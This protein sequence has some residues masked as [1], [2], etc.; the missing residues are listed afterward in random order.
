MP[1]ERVAYH[2]ASLRA[3]GLLILLTILVLTPQLIWGQGSTHS[4]IYNLL[5]THQI[6]EGF[7]RGD[8]YPR[9][10]PESFSG[11]GSPTFF[12]YGPFFHLISGA[13]EY[14]GLRTVHAVTGATALV[15]LGSGCGMYAWLRHRGTR[16]LLGAALYMLAPYH[17]F[18]IYARGALAEAAAFIWVPLIAL[19]IDWLPRRRGVVLLGV[20]FAGLILTHLP[21]AV[22]VST[23]L[24][25]PFALWRGWR[26]R[27]VVWP[28][29]VAALL[30]LG[31]SAFYWL[32]ALTLQA[33]ISTQLLWGP[34]Y[35]PAYWFNRQ[36]FKLN[37]LVLYLV[38]PIALAVLAAPARSIWSAVAV[39]AV[40]AILG[41]IPFIWDLPILA[42]TQFP[43]RLLL[44]AEFAAITA[45]MATP[46]KGFVLS[47]GRFLMA[48]PITIAL[49]AM[50]TVPRASLDE[51]AILRHRPDAPEYL[52][53]GLPTPGVGPHQR[54]ADVSAYD[55]LP[56]GE[57]I[58]AT[59]SGSL[60][61]GHA[62]FPIWRVTRDGRRVPSSGPL[63][64]FAAEPGVYRIERKTL[65]QEAWGLGLSSGALLALASL[66]LR[67]A[68]SLE[69]R[70]P[71]RSSP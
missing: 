4:G 6:A 1:G 43:F 45:I 68:M 30:G 71:R 2:H 44:V 52:P 51:A 61:V 29:V 55:I 10:F 39:V 11:L 67:G 64:T 14:A 7:H 50:V 19:G 48:A 20:A 54:W 35:E 47:I 3:F 8:L 24:I 17:L 63:I 53:R 27:A 16:P 49:V 42:K 56:R 65:W 33:H 46:P 18:D 31:L 58:V 40:F 28:G 23:F 34:F 21:S 36:N 12:F 57:T 38:F 5:W 69:R 13:L 70:R 32:P 25:L 62:A 66:L 22:L 9:W 26:N 59:G 37:H 15:L 41:L 60:T